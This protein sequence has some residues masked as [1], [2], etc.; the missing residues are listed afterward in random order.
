MPNTPLSKKI[1]DLLGGLVLEV[2]EKSEENGFEKLTWMKGI[3][4]KCNEEIQSILAQELASAKAAG[5]AEEREKLKNPRKWKW[6]VSDKPSKREELVISIINNYFDEFGKN[7]SLRTIAKIYGSTHH[8]IEVAVRSLK[9]KG[10]NP[11]HLSKE[12]DV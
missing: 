10:I 9:K 3:A 1:E 8:N 12:M 6:A 5:A 7:P 11:Y 4:K 2:I